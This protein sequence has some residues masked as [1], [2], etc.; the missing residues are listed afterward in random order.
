MG[1]VRGPREISQITDHPESPFGRESRKNWD[2]I[3]VQIRKRLSYGAIEI[4]IHKSDPSL[5]CRPRRFPQPAILA[6]HAGVQSIRQVERQV[7]RRDQ[8]LHIGQIAQ[9]MRR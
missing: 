9:P 6:P 7:Q 5:I 8:V 1:H 4:S 3:V 2:H